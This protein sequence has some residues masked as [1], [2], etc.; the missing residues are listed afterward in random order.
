MSWTASLCHLGT[1]GNVTVDPGSPAPSPIFYFVV[2]AQDATHEGSYGRKSSGLERP[3]AMEVGACDLPQAVQGSFQTNGGCLMNG[4]NPPPACT[5]GQDPETFS[6]YVIC[7]SACNAAW[8]ANANS[9]GGFYHALQI[10]QTFGDSTLG[11][12]GG[13]CGS[14][15]GYCQGGTSCKMNGPPTFDGSGNDCGSDEIGPI[16]C[17]TVPWQCLR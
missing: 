9:D 6:P 4:K 1:S 16:L 8:I 12:F 2:V 17:E 11:Q 3:E 7:S 13:T 5:S 14:V 15:C 10:C